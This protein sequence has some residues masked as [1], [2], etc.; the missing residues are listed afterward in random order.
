MRFVLK[1]PVRSEDVDEALHALKA[2]LLK[3]EIA[4]LSSLIIT[5]TAHKEGSAMEAV[6]KTNTPRPVQLDVEKGALD[7]HHAVS[8]E[9]AIIQQRRPTSLRTGLGALLGS[10]D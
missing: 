4:S 10:G 5:C 8:A 1:E 3:H 9:D 6:D 7:K 2:F